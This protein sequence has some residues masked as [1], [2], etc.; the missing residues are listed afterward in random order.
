MAALDDVAVLQDA[1]ER[2]RCI[3]EAVPASIIVLDR[4]GQIVDVNPHHVA[5][6]GRGR[7]RKEDY[8][9]QSILTRRTFVRAGRVDLV[10]RLL[11]GHVIDERE[12]LL[13][14]T[15]GDS[16]AY[17]HLRGVP[18]RRDGEVIGAVL[19]SED[20][21]ALK[22]AQLELQAHRDAL[23]QLV[24]ERTAELRAA[25]EQLTTALRQVR[26]LGGLLPI[27]ASCKNI[28]DDA[29]YW[30]RVEVYLRD[31]SDANFSHAICPTCMASLYPE[32]PPPA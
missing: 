6:L 23:E 12:V 21:T 20:V 27:C 31:H 13:P 16:A 19:L 25:V 9:G 11:D 10:Q 5:Q 8:V 1:A 30:H 15:S 24:E 29:G 4:D 3:F 22:V 14:V 7:T 32:Y 28:R 2:Y 17:V 26:T 18:I